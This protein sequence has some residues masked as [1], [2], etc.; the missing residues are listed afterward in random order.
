MKL[1]MGCMKSYDDEYNICPHCGY[2][3]NSSPVEENQLRPGS[4]L[5]NKYIVGKAIGHGGFG[6]TYLGYDPELKRKIAIKEYMPG[7]FSNR[8]P[9]DMKVCVYE[10]DKR[11]QFE[12]G[13]KKFMEEA[14][15]IAKFQDKE[16][17]IQIFDCFQENNTAYLVMEYLEGETLKEKVK[18]EGRL[19][20]EESLRI[21]V[22]ILKSLK[23]VHAVGILHRDIAPDN[24]ML[25]TAGEAKLI[26]FGAS[27]FATTGHSRSLTV[28]I[29]QGYA[30]VE[31]YNS[32]G[33]QGPWTDVYGLAATFYFMLTGKT[34][35]DAM[36][37]KARD[38]MKVPSKEGA[39]IGKNIDVAIM[40]AMNV[41]IE[42]RTKTMEDFEKELMAIG[43]VA[44]VIE[45]ERREDLG[46]MPLWLKLSLGGVATGI[47]VF[48]ALL[49]TGVI[50]FGNLTSEEFQMAQGKTYVPAFVNQVYS[51]AG[52]IAKENLVQVQIV[53]SKFSDEIA[54]E[55][56]LSQS[57]PSGSE[58]VKNSM[59]DLVV[60][61]GREQAEVPSLLGMDVEE[62]KKALENA[63]LVY[64]IIEVDNNAVKGSVV[65]QSKDALSLV[66][67]GFEITLEVS[68]GNLGD[69]DVE[70]EV[71]LPSFINMSYEEAK[72]ALGDL[73][74]QVKA[75]PK[76]SNDVKKGYVI[77]Q[78]SA[79][80]TVLH[81]GDVVELTYSLGKEKVNVPSL[82]FKAE[83]EARK[84]LDKA[85][86]KVKITY[87][88]DELVQK[89]NV[90]SQSIAGGT[91]VETGT[92]IT[93]KVS[94][95]PLEPIETS[96]STVTPT[97]EPEW[98]GWVESLPS[99]V[100]DS[101][102]YIESK[103]Q[104]SYRDKTTINS[105]DA[106][107]ANQGYT[108]ESTSTSYSEYG[109]WSDWGTDAI[110][111]TDLMKVESQLRY[112]YRDKTVTTSE[113]W[114]DWSGWQD[115]AVSAT[116]TREVQTQMVDD[117]NSPIYKTYYKYSKYSI[118]ASGSWHTGPSAGSL[119]YWGGT[120]Q[121][122]ETGWMESPKAVIGT[123][124]ASGNPPIY[125]GN[126]YNQQTK[127]EIV[128]YNQKTQYMYRDLQTSYSESWSAWSDY[129]TNVV[130]ASD[131][132]EVQTKYY[133]RYA[134]RTLSYTYTYSKWGNWSAYSDST[135]S[136][137]TTREV[138]TKQ[139][140]RY[141]AK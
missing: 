63:G 13:L 38:M 129:S 58:V 130:S 139:L 99:G 133:Y 91:L 136:S 62:A 8:V 137:S 48:G 2:V 106:N 22:P 28:L 92:E 124:G 5:H 29:K 93:L 4:V 25:T 54:N 10:G 78:S 140:Y 117:T 19:T 110:T 132:R 109:G 131:T 79:E 64:K 111:A 72:K 113:Y 1:C 87:E 15:R 65:T 126:W 85:G 112:S 24:I 17:I 114:G 102:Y 20:L 134:T 76:Y 115:S 118:Y 75:I 96:E 60:S 82:V 49:L 31:Q 30:P 16:G 51:K 98:S 36:E 37:R 88:N 26:D 95:G 101:S 83:S 77:E 45:P 80:G 61:A 73:G 57:L 108:M 127:Q 74:L 46:R 69:I 104:Y 33:D 138:R 11:E 44:R 120:P 128:G 7:E 107:L 55:M 71:T 122:E 42:Y 52:D 21:I 50:N 105:Q 12:S 116:S 121:Y 27:R 97:P 66:D 135:V 56:V 18:R 70:A 47:C 3:E 34:P 9:G 123:S 53:D 103:T 41:G 84:V 90:I 14:K 43:E 35:Q 86:L 89:G 81:Q 125:D 141:K 40:N 39:A 32:R 119:A 59:I 67:K 100:S 68:N 6:V 23:E 94:L